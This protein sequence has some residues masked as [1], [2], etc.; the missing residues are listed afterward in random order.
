[1]GINLRQ[2]IGMHVREARKRR[3]LTQQEL[4][5]LVGVNPETISNIERGR[6]APSIRALEA[7][8][9][10]LGVAPG[11]LLG[12]GD[13]DSSSSPRRAEKELKVRELIRRLS[14]RDLDLAIRQLEALAEARAGK[15]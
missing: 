7:L 2:T 12:R 5:A 9:E 13:D 15:Q 14:D 10:H 1:M 3:R 6:Y 4:A 8:C 11:D